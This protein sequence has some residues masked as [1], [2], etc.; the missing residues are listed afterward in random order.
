MYGNIVPSDP[1]HQTPPKVMEV[2]LG[3]RRAC[4]TNGHLEGQTAH[5]PHTD[6]QGASHPQSLC[7]APALVHPHSALGSRELWSY[8]PHLC[9]RSLGEPREK[10]RHLGYR[11]GRGDTEERPRKAETRKGRGQQRTLCDDVPKPPCRARPPGGR[12]RPT[13]LTTAPGRGGGRG[14]KKPKDTARAHTRTRAH[15]HTHTQ[16]SLC[17]T[18]TI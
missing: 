14:W 15:T 17:T 11:G 5:W 12:L 10:P 8:H 7:T 2:L 13:D 6:S 4:S 16:H 3:S 18:H 1:L 9:L